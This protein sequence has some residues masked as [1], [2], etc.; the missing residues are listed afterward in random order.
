MSRGL[1]GT[2]F[3]GG[4]LQLLLVAL[5]A[6]ADV[7]LRGVHSTVNLLI[8]LMVGVAFG[9]P[10][11][12]VDPL[13]G[14]LRMLLSVGLCL[15]FQVAELAHGILLGLTGRACRPTAFPAPTLMPGTDA[16]SAKMQSGTDLGCCP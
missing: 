3:F 4:G 15:L 13:V 14:L 7:L 6:P 12:L 16:T 10:R 1:R 8:V 9:E 5:L 11:Y 2:G